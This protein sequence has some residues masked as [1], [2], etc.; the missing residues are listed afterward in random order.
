LAKGEDKKEQF[1]VWSFE[2]SVP[3]YRNAI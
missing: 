2:F 3:G 1:I